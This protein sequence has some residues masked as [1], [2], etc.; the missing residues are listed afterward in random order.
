MNFEGEAFKGKSAIQ[1]KLMSLGS[2]AT[3]KAAAIAHD[4]RTMDFSWGPI[5]GQTV[6]ILASG[7]LKIDGGNPLQ[8][9]QVL[10]LSHINGN[11]ALANDMFR[12]IYS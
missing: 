7:S 9:A 3:N 10:Q 5:A 1:K 11:W 6:L 8:F 4:V 2:A 12:F